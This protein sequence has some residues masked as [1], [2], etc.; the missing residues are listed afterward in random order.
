MADPNFAASDAEAEERFLRW[1]HLDPFPEIQPALLNSADI[2]D[3]VAACGI[4]FPFHYDSD[5][6]KPASYEVAL[7]GTYV[8]WDEFG[9]RQQDDIEAGD[10]FTLEPNSIAFVTLEP[11][12][13]LPDYMAIRFNLK[14]TQ[15]YRGLLLGTGP[16]VDPGFQDRLSLP[17]HNLT[18]NPYV[19]RGGEGLIWMEFTKLSPA[20]THGTPTRRKTPAAP[21]RLGRFISLPQEKAKDLTVSDYLYKA[22]PHRPIR[23]SVPEAIQLAE[24]AA[25][26]AR[27]RVA[28]AQRLITTVGI[29]GLA[30][31]VIALTTIVLMT[32]S[33]VGDTNARLE[34]LSVRPSPGALADASDLQQLKRRI[35]ALEQQINRP[36]SPSPCP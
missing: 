24:S 11:T 22:D 2:A 33:L 26:D 4:L 6:L 28:R 20:L 25:T 3:Y 31:I 7:L 5:F 21:Q 15:V 17:L 23:S 35:C 9:A 12:I 34:Q 29:G 36:Q 27:D 13:R 18:V 19:L 8:Y 16:L 1:Q 32:F 14:I 10:P 30:G